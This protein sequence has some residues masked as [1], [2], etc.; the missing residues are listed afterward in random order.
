MSYPAHKETGKR[1]QRFELRA[2]AWKALRSPVTFALLAAFAW[3]AVYNRRFW[4]ETMATM[5]SFS[6]AD[7][8]FLLSV[9]ALLWALHAGL[10][11]LIPT[12]P[13]LKAVTAFLFVAASVG[14]YFA[15]T[16]GVSIDTET[17]RNLFETDAREAIGL[18][19]LRSVFY[20]SVLGLAP[21]VLIVRM[22]LAKLSLKQHLLQRAAFVAAFAVLVAVSFASLSAHYASFLREHKGVRYLVTPANVV[23]GTSAYVSQA[24][25]GPVDSQ[26]L[27]LEAPV[28]R[29]A[30]ASSPRPLL[31]FLVIGETARSQNFQLGGYARPTNPE[32]SRRDVQYFS[33]V[34]SCGTS[35]AI[36]LPCMFSGLGRAA[37]DVARAQRNTNLLDAL[38]SGGFR[39]QWRENNSGCKGICA[40][41]ES[42]DYT[43]RRDDKLCTKSGC[44]DEVMLT[45]LEQELAA[46]NRDTVVVFHQAGSHGP[47]YSERYPKHFETFSPACQGNELSRCKVEHVVNA[48]DNSI[49]YTDHN[50]ARQIDLLRSISAAADSILIYVSDHGESLG[51]RGMYLHGA[52]FTLAPAEQ[53][54]VPFVLWMSEGYRKRFA[55][56]EACLGAKG[57]QGF[58]HDHLYHSVLGALGVSTAR[59]QP[60]MDM[61]HECRSGF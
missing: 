54:R 28:R 33:N 1:S 57:Q 46:V 11:L 12:R 35:T 56:S 20:V 6:P 26:L 23:H 60:A 45:G 58:S 52:P 31:M 17:I 14:A 38:A 10:L 55:V 34:S 9:F 30:A 47:A 61:F 49:V 32:L 25:L 42:I 48:Y 22:R 37:F 43:L 53:T 21:A 13:L 2:S 3:V 27:D 51:E 7:I 39:V 41:V 15:D 59:Y 19:S 24:N 44:Y 4:S 40:R 36:S 18:F 16:Y 50:L 8:A 29:I 5:P